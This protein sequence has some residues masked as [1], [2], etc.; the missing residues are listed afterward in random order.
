MSPLAI[1]KSAASVSVVRAA[2]G[3]AAAADSSDGGTVASTDDT[4]PSTSPMTQRAMTMPFDLE[5]VR[6]L[7]WLRHAEP[8]AATG[9]IFLFHYRM[10]MLSVQMRDFGRSAVICDCVRN[11]RRP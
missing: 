5:R 3:A 9:E 8:M 2:S 10:H 6:C 11:G 4:A 7:E 1:E